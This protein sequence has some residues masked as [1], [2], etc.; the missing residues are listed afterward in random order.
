[1]QEAWLI[2]NAKLKHIYS[3]TSKKFLLEQFFLIGL[4]QNEILFYYFLS[5]M[6]NLMTNGHFQ[7]CTCNLRLS[8]GNSRSFTTAP[9]WDQ[10]HAS[11]ATWASAV[12]FLTHWSAVRTPWNIILNITYG[13]PLWVDEQGLFVMDYACLFTGNWW[14]KEQFS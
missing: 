2:F 12:R 6:A 14:M 8:C 13:F 7:S 9:R 10:T 5:L 4:L 11:T 1:M 3:N